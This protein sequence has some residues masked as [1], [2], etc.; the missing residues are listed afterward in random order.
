MEGAFQKE[1]KLKL[2]VIYSIIHRVKKCV[3]WFFHARHFKVYS[4]S[5]TILNSLKIQGHKYISIDKKVY[6]HKFVWLGAYKISEVV[7]ELVISEGVCLGNFNHITCGKK[8]FIGKNVLTADKVFIT[9]HLHEYGNPN[10][11]IIQQGIRIKQEVIIG[12]GAWIGENVSIIGAN[13]G[14][15]S[16][17]GANSVVSSDIPDYSIAVGSPARV[18]KR[19]DFKNKKWERI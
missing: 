2:G 18:I 1:F 14:K 19:Y 12:D 15:N 17:I 16:I 8:V 13:V 6:V 4:F 3:F 5:S 9:D 7:P 10:I 11:P